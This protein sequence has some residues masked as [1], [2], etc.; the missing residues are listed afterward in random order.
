[1]ECL[2]FSSGTGILSASSSTRCRWVLSDR[3]PCRYV[4]PPSTYSGNTILRL[5]SPKRLGI[6][7]GCGLSDRTVGV[8]RLGW[9]A[10]GSGTGAFAGTKAGCP[11]TFSVPKF[12][13]HPSLINL[14]VW[15]RYPTIIQRRTKRVC[16]GEGAVRELC[17]TPGA[18]RRWVEQHRR[19][20]LWKP[21]HPASGTAIQRLL[22]HI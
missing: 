11:T 21:F 16:R 5:Q 18:C 12:K 17:R 10:S 20:P 3:T 1:M 9:R 15:R 19:R 6:R 2:I 7:L 8:G 22:S 14:T 4:P 13:V